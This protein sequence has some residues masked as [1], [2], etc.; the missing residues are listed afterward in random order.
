MAEP[1]VEHSLRASKNERK[2]VA[3]FESIGLAHT[4]SPQPV[5][6][7]AVPKRR[8]GWKKY[9]HLQKVEVHKTADV[10]ASM[11]ATSYLQIWELDFYRFGKYLERDEV[12]ANVRQNRL[13]AT[14][15][16]VVAARRG[17]GHEFV[18]TGQP[19]LTHE[20]LNPLHGHVVVRL[21][22]VGQVDAEDFRIPLGEYEAFIELAAAVR[23]SPSD[24]G[25]ANYRNSI[26]YQLKNVEASIRQELENR[27]GIT[28]SFVT[29]YS[30]CFVA[31]DGAVIKRL[32][33]KS[34]VAPL[35]DAEKAELAVAKRSVKNKEF[36]RQA[37]QVLGTLPAFRIEGAQITIGYH[38]I[39]SYTSVATECQRV[40]VGV[41]QLLGLD[42]PPKVAV[43]MLYGHGIR[44]KLQIDFRMA[45][46]HNY[47][48]PGS[49]RVDRVPA[50]VRSIEPHVTHDPAIALYAC[51]TGRANRPNSD[52]MFGRVYPCEEMGGDSLAWTLFYEL[53]R[54]NIQNP[55]IWAHTTAGHTTRNPRLRVY[56]SKGFADLPNLLTQT[57]RLRESFLNGYRRPFSHHGQSGERRTRRLRNVN[58]LR[59]ICTV[60]AWYLPWE[61]SGAADA[62]QGDPSFRPQSDQTMTAI[63]DRIRALMPAPAAIA[64]KMTYEQAPSSPPHAYIKGLASGHTDTRLSQH[65]KYSHFANL[66]DPMR[67]S[68]DIVRKLQLLRYRAARRLD[69]VR[70]AHNGNGVVLKVRPNNAANRT[71]VMGQA[72]RMVREELIKSAKLVDREIFI[73]ATPVLLDVIT[74][75]HNE[76]ISNV[77]GEAATFIRENND[78]DAW[79]LVF[80]QKM[81]WDRYE[82]LER[83][84]Q[85]VRNRGPWDYKPMIREHYGEWAFDEQNRRAY[86][87]DVWSNLHYGY[88]GLAC[89][90][91][92]KLLLSGAGFAQW[93][94]GTVPDGYW[95]RLIESLGD[96]FQSLDDPKDQE[97]IKAGF[98]L[99][100]AHKANVTTDHI[101]AEVRG[102]AARL[103]TRSY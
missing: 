2:V 27:G 86:S 88:L 25:F 21:R 56:C 31:N 58:M 16:G 40:K 81:P 55:S 20:T 54:Q 90:F 32:R 102:R 101:L 22:R 82:A 1:N 59:E 17:G 18:A 41:Q 97:A 72:E 12:D 80:P 47:N 69:P 98:A 9:K 95:D 75:I 49:L 57:T 103:N 36:H 67:L 5:R 15:P 14:F 73:S 51:S 70:L 11:N 30:A 100:K 6:V 68:V 53:R 83:W 99:W 3:R 91:S 38:L 84:Y 34:E 7:T 61:W 39:S 4:V 63:Y 96:I 42:T 10:V 62:K 8:E 23:T 45:S 74:F 71:R 24:T 60:S 48:Y 28:L 66:A 77:N 78:F 87:L 76:M 93:R 33:K 85:Q 92:E 29:D 19:T 79:Y 65:Y 13:L 52:T 64:D 35:S 37:E 46:T 89:D 94:A 50:F 26:P 43:I 44:T